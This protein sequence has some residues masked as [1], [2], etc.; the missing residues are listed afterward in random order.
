MWSKPIDLT[1]TFSEHHYFSG[2]KEKDALGIEI[3]LEGKNI[4]IGT[5]DDDFYAYWQRTEDGSLRRN[6]PGDQAIEYRF[7]KPLNLTDC[8]K[9]LAILEHRLTRKSVVV[10]PSPRASVHVHVNV[11]A[12]TMASVYN[13]ITLAFIFD[14]LLVS[15]NGSHRIGNNFCFRAKDAQ[16]VLVGLTQSLKRRGDLGE[17]SREHRYCSTN[18]GSLFKFGSIEFRSMECTVEKARLNNWVGVILALK[19][20]ARQYSNPTEIVSTF[21]LRGPDRFIV[22]TLGAKLAMPYI[23]VPNHAQ[24]VFD[25]LRLVQEFANASSWVPMKAED[26]PK[27]L[28]YDD[29]IALLQR[30]AHEAVIRAQ[31]EIAPPVEAER[32]HPEGIQWHRAPPGGVQAFINEAPPQNPI[33]RWGERPDVA[34][35]IP[36][37]RG[38]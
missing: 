28:T 24:M 30:Q 26:R 9:A 21:S 19:N 5:D 11:S 38:R 23:R 14:E 33:P 13:F 17:F 31:V 1:S 15:Q 37:R 2:P 7:R 4:L 34:L 10:Y 25:G 27:K 8:E 35:P 29:H 3:E 6:N 22:D 12:D 32:G 16:G 20:A 36:P 18:V